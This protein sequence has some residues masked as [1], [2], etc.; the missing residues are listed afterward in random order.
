MALD[1]CLVAAVSGHA[2]L[3]VPAVRCRRRGPRRQKGVVNAQVGKQDLRKN[4]LAAAQRSDRNRK[5][6]IQVVVAAVLVGLVAAIIIGIAMGREDKDE[7]TAFNPT[8]G[9]DSSQGAVPPNLTP[10]GAIRVGDAD[11]KVKVQVVADPQCPACAMFEKANGEVLE[12]AVT[13]GTAVVEYNIISFLDRASSNQ[14]SSRAA[15]AAYVVGTTDPSKFQQFLAKLFAAQTPEGGGPGLTDDQLIEIATAAG[16]TDPAVA[17]AIRDNK[18]AAFVKA[19][20][21]AVFDAGVKS[22][23]SVYVNGEQVQTQQELMSQGGLRPVIEA[24]AK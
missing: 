14:Y 1:V 10:G 11:A 5:I 15:N 3:A 22:T 23:P 8:L 16:Y 21:Q 12:Q 20:T 24:A 2:N 6:A 13:D 19:E 7:S 18:Y 4:P 9:F 17:Q